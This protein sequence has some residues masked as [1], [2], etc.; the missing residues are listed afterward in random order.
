MFALNEDILCVYA[1]LDSLIERAGL[2]DGER[3]TVD[4]LMKGYILSDIAEH[5]GKARQNFDILFRRAVKKI[6]KR[7]TMDWEECTGARLD[8]GEW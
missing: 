2:S 1:D 3:N 7:N 4:L 5:Y 8:D 6:V